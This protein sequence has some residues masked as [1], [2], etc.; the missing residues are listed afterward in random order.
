MILQLGVIQYAGNKP[1]APERQWLPD[2][3]GVYFVEHVP[4][5]SVRS[6]TQSQRR[7]SFYVSPPFTARGR[8][9]CLYR[10]P[11]KRRMWHL[12]VLG[13]VFF[14]RNAFSKTPSEQNLS[15]LFFGGAQYRRRTVHGP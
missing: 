5:V 15:P 10:V 6:A 13:A 8:L 14:Q 4:A 11:S 12:I 9:H 2:E 7:D 1:T 3:D